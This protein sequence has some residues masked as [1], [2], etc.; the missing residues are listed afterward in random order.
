TTHPG[1]IGAAA[2]AMKTMGL[3]DLVLVAPRDFP[4]EEA[5]ARASGAADLLER[6]R[7]VESLP[8]ALADCSFVVGTSARSRTVEWPVVDP[9]EC[10]ERVWQAV[11][12]GNA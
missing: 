10:A 3:D 6:A 7:V 1:N 8:E 12:A 2:R 5:T 9:R 4:S 11:D